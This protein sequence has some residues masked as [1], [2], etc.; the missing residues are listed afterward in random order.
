MNQL[1]L[2]YQ[3]NVKQT[4]NNYYSENSE[5]EL[6]LDS[7]KKIF[8]N[9]NNQ[10]FIWGSRC[11][12]KSHIL[13]SACNYF[14]DFKKRCVY[15]PMKNFVK[16]NKD[17]LVGVDEYDL[18]CVDDID[19][20]FGIEEWEKSFFFLINKILDNSKKIIYTSSMNT[21]SKNINLQ[22]L[23]SRLKWGLNLKIS[24]ENDVVKEKI[25]KKIIYE[26][27]YNISDNVSSF[28][29]NR[30]DRDLCSLI[31]KIHKLG[32]HSFSTKKRVNLKD[33]NNILSL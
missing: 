22:D 26:E 31:N 32:H 20:I 33:V 3:K 7:I 19:L 12:G 4:F 2:K 28:L 14:N 17:I 30:K 1:I 23:Q 25:L 5:N 16:F 11:S 27:E 8:E 29:L 18:I 10:I 13:Y 24:N 15:L 21:S 9:K 6:T